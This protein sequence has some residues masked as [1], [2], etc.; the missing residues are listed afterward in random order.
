[1][2][3]YLYICNNVQSPG[4]HGEFEVEHS[5]KEELKACPKCLEE[6][7]TDQPVQR[8]ICAATPG[9]VELTGEDLTNYIKSDAKRIS[10]EAAKSES[11]YANLLG[12]DKMQ[13]IQTKIDRQRR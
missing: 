10:S 5:I 13:Q 9:K 2:P 4:K 11:K 3:T 8:L 6:G 12:Y 7:L 1:M